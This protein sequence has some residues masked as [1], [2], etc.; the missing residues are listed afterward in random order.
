MKGAIDA[1]VALSSHLLDACHSS[2][3]SFRLNR[4]KTTFRLSIWHILF[5][6][7]HVYVCVCMCVNMYLLLRVRGPN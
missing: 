1:I 2:Y 4:N 5:A 6:N 3:V 7:S